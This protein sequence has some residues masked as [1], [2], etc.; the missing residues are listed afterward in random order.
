MTRGP[1]QPNVEEVRQLSVHDVGIVRWIHHDGVDAYVIEMNKV[2]GRGTADLQRRRRVPLT[3]RKLPLR[4]WGVSRGMR[5][6]LN[7]FHQL[8]NAS[9]HL[10][11]RPVAA[12]A[13]DQR[14]EL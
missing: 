3:Q 11:D 7:H 4:V 5:I 10:L 14:S 9:R 13:D 6:R 2:V 1:F 12:K 8:A